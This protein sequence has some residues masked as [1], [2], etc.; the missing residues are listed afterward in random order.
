[1]F[2]KTKDWLLQEIKIDYKDQV[3]QVM[4]FEAFY[5]LHD[6]SGLERANKLALLVDDEEK[7]LLFPEF[8]VCSLYLVKLTSKECKQ[9]FFHEAILKSVEYFLFKNGGGGLGH[10]V[11]ISGEKV[12]K[13][14]PAGVIAWICVLVCRSLKTVTNSLA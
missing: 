7:R 3:I 10:K 9:R 11:N 6:V 4:R 2:S 14:V 1:M 13:I 5:Q 8:H 12:M